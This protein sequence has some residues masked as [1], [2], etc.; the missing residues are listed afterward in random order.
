MLCFDPSIGS[1]TMDFQEDFGSCSGYRSE[2]PRN[3]MR[4][5]I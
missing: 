5:R 4:S 3:P 2:W 1:A